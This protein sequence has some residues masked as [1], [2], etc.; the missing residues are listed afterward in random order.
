MEKL[1]FPNVTRDMIFFEEIVFYSLKNGGLG[2]YDNCPKG[3][4][5]LFEDSY[6]TGYLSLFEFQ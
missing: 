5:N 1:V 6:F 4:E 3:Q 2:F